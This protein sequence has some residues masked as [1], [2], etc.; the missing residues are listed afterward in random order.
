MAANWIVNVIFGV[1]AF[2]LTFVFSI[3]NNTWQT[4]IFRSG[5]GFL[6]FFVFG[7]ILR[8]ILYQISVMKT[9]K[10]LEDPSIEEEWE[11]EDYL[12]RIGEKQANESSFQAVPLHS[13]HNGEGAKDPETI[14]QIMQSWTESNKEG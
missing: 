14:A 7:Y 13:L 1:A 3:G 8:S 10:R 11:T 2:L 12:N 5:I 4:S 9:L 6:L